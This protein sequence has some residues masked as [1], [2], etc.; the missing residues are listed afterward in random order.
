MIFRPP[1]NEI[2][3]CWENQNSSSFLVGTSTGLSQDVINMQPIQF[4]PMGAEQV[5]VEYSILVRQ[6]ALDQN[7]Y[8]YWLNLEN[9]TQLTGSI[10]D[11]QPTQVTGNIHSL[12][13]RT[14]P[15]FGYVSASTE[16]DKRIFISQYQISYWAASLP[17]CTETDVPPSDISA[18]ADSAF[19][20]PITEVVGIYTGSTPA[21]VDCRFGG[22]TTSEP[23]YWPN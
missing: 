6:F 12:S 5:L 20:I 18:F 23:S 2:Y 13:N 14:E 21:C 9:S 4:I 16:S 8:T 1:Q 11:P 7:A 17:D 15:V 19:L 10:F 3:R 22:G